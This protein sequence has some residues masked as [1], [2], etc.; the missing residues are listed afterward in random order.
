MNCLVFCVLLG[1][2]AT[3][4]AQWANQQ[5]PNQFPA[6]N[7]P[8]PFPNQ[9]GS[10]PNQPGAQY[11]NINDMCKQPG[12]NCRVDSR[13]AEETSVTDNKGQTTKYTRVCDDRGCYDRKVYSGSTAVSTNCILV[14]ICAL[15]AAKIYFH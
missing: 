15:L 2:I 13:Y 10:F 14:T 3:A 9:P 8:A 7:Q 5:Y 12:A 6:P 4:S 1:L 11:P